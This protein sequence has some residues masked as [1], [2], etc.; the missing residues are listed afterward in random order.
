MTHGVT[1]RHECFDL[2]QRRRNLHPPCHRNCGSAIQQQGQLYL[3]DLGCP[4]ASG[5]NNFLNPYGFSRD[6]IDG[7]CE[8]DLYGL[9]RIKKTASMKEVKTAYLHEARKYHPDK[10]GAPVVDES[11]INTT[12]FYVSAK[13]DDA[14]TD[15]PKIEITLMVPGE[16]S[17]TL[18]PYEKNGKPFPAI[19]FPLS[20]SEGSS[21]LLLVERELSRYFKVDSVKFVNKKRM[22][23]PLSEFTGLDQLI[24]WTQS[25]PFLIG[26]CE[27]NPAVQYAATRFRW[28]K[29]A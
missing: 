27:M 24:E 11:I 25:D 16:D 13:A 5:A 7:K 18:R 22:N 10:I 17:K 9:L 3:S 19:K 2:P 29:N 6:A 8:D 26:I 28:V 4:K 21:P 20:G 14:K 12:G 15:D 23:V 1:R